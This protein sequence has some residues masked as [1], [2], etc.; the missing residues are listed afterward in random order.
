MCIYIYIH[1][2]RYNK[3][4]HICV[5]IHMYIL[6]MYIY[7]YRE[8]ERCC[9]CCCD[10]QYISMFIRC[11]GMPSISTRSPTGRWPIETELASRTP[12]LHSPKTPG[13]FRRFAEMSVRTTLASWKT[14]F[15]RRFPQKTVP[16]TPYSS[17]LSYQCYPR[18]AARPHGSLPASACRSQICL[19]RLVLY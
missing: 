11:F 5:Y 4:V 6:C 10:R 19:G 13:G 8:R 14:V 1:R 3:C 16:R 12:R 2:E 7:I 17:T 15:S 9:C 18:A